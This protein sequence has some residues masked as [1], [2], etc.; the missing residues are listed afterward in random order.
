MADYKRKMGIEEDRDSSAYWRE[1]E[2]RRMNSPDAYDSVRPAGTRARLRAEKS[3]ALKDAALGAA[4]AP[5][6][7]ALETAMGRRGREGKGPIGAGVE[8]LAG[9]GDRL[10]KSAREAADYIGSKVDKYKS[11]RDEEKGIER[12]LESQDRRESRGMKKGGKVKAAPKQS[13]KGWG[14]ARGARAAKVY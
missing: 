10:A 8:H 13:A 11:A 2:A 9:T 3:E 7:I 4:I 14:K 6:G 5:V 1:K 12:E